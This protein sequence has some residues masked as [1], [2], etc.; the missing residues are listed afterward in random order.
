MANFGQTALALIAGFAQ[1]R[2]IK[3]QREQDEK[4]KKARMTLFELQLEQAKAQ[5]RQRIQAEEARQKI[6]S[7]LQGSGPVQAAEPYGGVGPVRGPRPAM[8]LTELLADPENAVLALQSGL[9]GPD[10][11]LGAQE[12]NQIRVLR[13]LA[14][15]P[16]LMA[17]ETELRRAGASQVNL[18]DLGLNKPPPGYARPDPTKP[19]LVREPGAPPTPG[20]EASDKAFGQEYAAWVA[21]GGFADVEKGLRQ[22]EEA[23]IALED[24]SKGRGKNLTGP[25]VAKIPEFAKPLFNP[26][27]VAVRDTVEEIVQRNLRLVLGAQFTEKE[28]E[29]LIARSYNE[30]LSEAENA[31]RVGRLIQQIRS[32]AKAKQEAAEYFAEHGTLEGFKGKVWT[33]ADFDPETGRG[34]SGSFDEDLPEGIPSGSVMIG[35]SGGKPV[36]QTPDGRRLIVE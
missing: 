3:K 23:K 12:P 20:Q 14:A 18:G 32:A 33:L 26:D 24:A 7:R 1:G 21:G 30:N 17:A 11:L 15:D 27:A 28:G 9:V 8:S 31:K 2:Q 4:E 13:A 6:F 36:Y 10:A 29:R 35:T 16:A 19:G 25:V 5:E 34:A 22:L